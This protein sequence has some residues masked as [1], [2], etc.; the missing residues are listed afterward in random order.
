[1]VLVASWKRV[2]LAF[3]MESIVFF[4]GGIVLM[5]TKDMLL[6]SLSLGK[7]LGLSSQLFDICNEGPIIYEVYLCY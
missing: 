7:L 2:T 4:I 3:N 1:M 6:A 5:L